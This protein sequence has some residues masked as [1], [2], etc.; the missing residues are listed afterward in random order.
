MRKRLIAVPLALSLALGLGSPALAQTAPAAQQPQQTTATKPAKDP[1][2]VICE[3]QQEP[4]SRIASQRVC[5][6]RAEWAEEKRANRQDIDK[7]QT[8]RGD[9]SH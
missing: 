3:K 4:G 6:T 2:E 9:I 7:M 5:K 8:Q 1:N